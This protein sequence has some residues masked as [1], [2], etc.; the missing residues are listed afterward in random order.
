M[1]KDIYI[2][3]TVKARLRS[4]GKEQARSLVLSCPDVCQNFSDFFTDK[5][6]QFSPFYLNLKKIGR[7]SPNASA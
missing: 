3:D 1:N 7:D 5:L 4:E 2:K 6:A